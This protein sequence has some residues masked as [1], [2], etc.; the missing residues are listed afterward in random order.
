MIFLTVGTQLPFDRL[1][2]AV[3]A[4]CT[5]TGKGRD[6]FG[7]IGKLDAV[8]YRPQAFHWR[9]MLDPVEFDHRVQQAALI[10]SHAGIGSI[11]TAMSYHI[12]IIV[13]P[14]RASLGEQRNDHQ[15]ATAQKLAMRSGLF[16]APSEDAIPDLIDGILVM[17]EAGGTLPRYA[18]KSLIET[19]RGFIFSGVAPEHGG[20]VQKPKAEQ[21][22]FEGATRL[23]LTPEDDYTSK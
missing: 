3:D 11:I 21:K 7:Q 15:L 18:D 22:K 2:A 16:V 4:W 6:V 20:A 13:L 17:R 12:P 1:T 8:S 23:T 9:Q 14:R 10:I 19:V 5:K